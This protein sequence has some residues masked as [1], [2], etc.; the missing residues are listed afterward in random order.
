[1]HG[2]PVYLNVVVAGQMFE[3]GKGSGMKAGESLRMAVHTLRIRGGLTFAPLL[4][5]ESRVPLVGVVGHRRKGR[6]HI[7]GLWCRWGTR[8]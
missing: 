7:A 3:Q 4:T 2:V 8:G 5:V 1:M 6:P